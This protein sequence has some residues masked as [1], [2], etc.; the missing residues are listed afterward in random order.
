MSSSTPARPRILIV[1]SQDHG[2]LF[3]AV[4]LLEGMNIDAL[5]L[6]PQR[7]HVLNCEDLRIPCAAFDSCSTLLNQ[8]RLY[9]PDIVLLFSGYLLVMNQLLTSQKL[10]QLVTTLNSEGIMLATSD[11]FLGLLSQARVRTT[12]LNHPAADQIRR[13][14]EQ[15]A[16]LLQNVTHVSHAPARAELHTTHLSFFNPRYGAEPAAP[17]AT[18]AEHHT[19]SRP[20]WLF[21][22]ST[23]DFGMQCHLHGTDAF[24]QTLA[25]LLRQTLVGRRLPVLVAPTSCLAAVQRLNAADEPVHGYDSLSY[26]KFRDLLNRAESA[27]YWNQ[28]SASVLHRILHHQP[29]FLFDQGHLSRA[30]PA[31]GRHARDH[32]F[33]D[34]ELPVL[35]PHQPL[36]PE[37]LRPLAALQIDG[38]LQPAIDHLSQTVD[39]EEFLRQ[40]AVT[41]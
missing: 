39:P 13:Q 10:E 37:A 26:E 18:A 27:F 5:L 14:F 8:V 15:V 34:C 3:N 1:V 32:F 9:R 41:S 30:V 33:R 20:T 31:F 17:Q 40:L 11:P 21:V 24:C 12:E 16:S 36:T 6:L 19:E 4:Y 35:E 2:E 22:L 28:F 23:E 38:L 29:V 25:N 7:L